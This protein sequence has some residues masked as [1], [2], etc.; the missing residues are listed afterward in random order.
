MK[1]IKRLT[2]ILISVAVVGLFG[3]QK[4]NNAPKKMTPKLWLQDIDYLIK[5]LE[6]RHIKPYHSISKQKVTQQINQLK[7]RLASLNSEEVYIEL[8][9][10]VR[11]LDDSHTGIFAN[12]SFYS[13]YPLRFFMFENNELR[14]TETS[15]KHKEI[16]G[17]KL[18]AI[19]NMPVKEAMNRVKT[20]AQNVDNPYSQKARTARYIRYAKFLKNLKITQNNQTAS[21][22]FLLAN[23]QTKNVQLKAVANNQYASTLTEK[24]KLKRLFTYDKSCLGT[25]YLWYKTNKDKSVGYL[26]FG[27][28]P[29]ALQMRR[30]GVA[31]SLELMKHNTKKLIVDLRNNGGGDFFVGLELGRILTNLDHINWLNGVY[32]LTSRFTYSAGMSNTAQFKELLNAKLVGEPTGSNPNDY[33]DAANFTLP[34]SKLWVMYSKRHYRFQDTVSGGIVPDVHIKPQWKDYKAGNDA[35]MQWVLGDM[36]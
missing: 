16:L 27:G 17:A 21:F 25:N 10:I 24:I 30:F 19:N 33:Q 26:Y 31:I 23:G 3:C 12:S 9:K 15:T 35:V 29:N 2:F 32:V 8:A 4:S 13:S 7:Q 36:R 11:S 20:I 22:R 34:H 14:V 18:L 6:K 5:N 1:S 28:Y